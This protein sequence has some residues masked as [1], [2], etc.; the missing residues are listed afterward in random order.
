MQGAWISGKGMRKK[1]RQICPFSG[2]TCCFCVINNVII[3]LLF[4]SLK[5][6]HCLY[7]HTGGELYYDLYIE[8]EQY[9]FDIFMVTFLFVLCWRGSKYHPHSKS[10]FSEIWK[11]LFLTSEI[12]AFRLHW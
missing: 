3:I 12:L 10:G 7:T 1:A 8:G 11:C 9:Q 6:T 2:A 5:Y 4:N